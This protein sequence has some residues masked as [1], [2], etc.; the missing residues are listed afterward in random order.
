MMMF[1][2]LELHTQIFFLSSY[3]ILLFLNLSQM[4]GE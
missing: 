4:V 2:L 3:I 1:I